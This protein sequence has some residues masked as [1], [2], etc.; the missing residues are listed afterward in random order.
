M[1]NTAKA[2][3]S[4]VVV[5]PANVEQAGNTVNSF[6]QTMQANPYGGLCL[7]LICA[8][9]AYIIASCINKRS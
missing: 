6:I 1:S 5:T 4:A 7:V 9:V 3:A 2:A 8:A